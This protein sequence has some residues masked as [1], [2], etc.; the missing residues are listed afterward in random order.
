MNNQTRIAELHAF[1]VEEGIELPLHAELI[2]W[3]EE[4]GCVVDLLTGRATLPVVGTPT[5]SGKAVNHLLTPEEEREYT[6]DYE[7][8]LDDVDWI[9]HGC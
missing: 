6:A 7:D 9:R 4:R 2:I 8:Y 3:L 1:A 5:P